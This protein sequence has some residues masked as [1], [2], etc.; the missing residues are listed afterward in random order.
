M[1]IARDERVYR[2]RTELI[3]ALS[4]VFPDGINSGIINGGGAVSSV[5]SA[6]E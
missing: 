1:N 3:S 2:V 6:A 4:E 5:N